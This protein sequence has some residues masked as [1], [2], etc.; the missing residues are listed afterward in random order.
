MPLLS[1]ANIKVN[2]KESEISARSALANHRVGLFDRRTALT[3]FLIP[4]LKTL[5]LEL[6]V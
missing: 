1:K 4:F 3:S 2:I 6:E 5:V